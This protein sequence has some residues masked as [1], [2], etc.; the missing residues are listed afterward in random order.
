MPNLD[1][2][3][4]KILFI[5]PIFYDYHIIIKEKLESLGPE[6]FFYPERDYSL[7]FSVVSNFFQ[8]KLDAFQSKYYFEILKKTEHITF[9]YLFVIKAYKMPVKFVEIFKA[10]Y[11]KAKTI[12]NQWDSAKNNSY[13]YLI[14]EFHKVLSFDI[15]DVRKNSKLQYLPNFYLDD[16][17]KI[18]VKSYKNDIRYDIFLVASFLPE[19]YAS[20]LKLIDFSKKNNLEYK[21]KLY[22]PFMSYIKEFVKGNRIDKNVIIFKPLSRTE[23][24]KMWSL[25]DMIYDIGSNKQTGLS[26][27]TIETI[28]VGKKLI[29]NN[30]FIKQEVIYNPDQ[31]LVINS[32]SFERILDFRNREF[33]AV[34]TNY[35][36]ESWIEKIFK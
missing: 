22:M 11:P 3:G 29:T 34:K 7:K 24:L 31:V 25:S 27:R 35:S 4:K 36:L 8:S 9:D 13:D 26:Q 18:D 2:K 23:Y 19:R 6:V 33:V 16:I 17:K 14:D 1:F 15:E 10:R 12:M 32:N 20:I 21:I 5:S 30:R 28:E